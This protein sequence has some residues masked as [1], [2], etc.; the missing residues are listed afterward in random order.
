MLESPETRN[1]LKTLKLRNRDLVLNFLRKAG[2]VSVNEMAR[3]TGL[4]KMTVHKIIDHY[5]EEG[6]VSHAGKGDSTDEGGKKPNLFIFNAFCRYIYAL[7]IGGGF[8]DSSIVNLRGETI[9]AGQRIPLGNIGFDDAVNLMAEE[10]HA[11]TTEKDLPFNS[12]IGVVVGCNG[13]VDV[14][15]GVCFTA[16]DCPHWG[17]NLPLRDRLGAKLPP[18]IRVYVDSWWRHLAQGELHNTGFDG[19]DRFF[20]LGN[21]GEFISGGLV[22]NGRVRHGKTGFAGEIGHLIV[23]PENGEKCLCGGT[24]CLGAMV[25]PRRVAS[26]AEQLRGEHPDSRIFAAG[27]P[28][29]MSALGAAADAG[30]ALARKLVD[31]MVRHFGVAVNNIVHVCDPGLVLLFG[32]YADAGE[33]FLQ[34]L[35]KRVHSLSLEG[36]DKNTEIEYSPVAPEHG[37]IGAAIHMAD[38]LFGGGG[39]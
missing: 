28:V 39:H 11:R 13:I 2:A 34:T 29:G 22:E 23:A 37:L 36:I 7:M 14:Q 5:L 38:T 31:E 20:L 3:A 25:S 16:Y 30:D 12:C 9:V 10:F 32:D 33:Y 8:L 24:G 17:M 1:S 4:S 19:R 35:R 6:I 15:N 26:L 18:G 27:L 21:C